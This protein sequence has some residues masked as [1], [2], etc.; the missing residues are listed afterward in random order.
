MFLVE[1]QSM[2]PQ[3]H[4][5]LLKNN[6]KNYFRAFILRDIQEGTIFPDYPVFVIH[7]DTYMQFT[8]YNIEV[9][10][11]NYFFNLKCNIIY[12]YIIFRHQPS[13]IIPL[14][15]FIRG[16]YYLRSNFIMYCPLVALHSVQII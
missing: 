16:K 12:I 11:A 4:N 2:L 9:E 7:N 10:D 8:Y 1:H 13:I 5:Y 3:L 6:K 14:L 15:L